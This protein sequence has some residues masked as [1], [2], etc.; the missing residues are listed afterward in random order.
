MTLRI[1]KN[2]EV[3]EK[4]PEKIKIPTK[5]YLTFAGSIGIMLLFFGVLLILSL[6]ANGCL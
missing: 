5:D 4:D 2:D 6:D 1:V 3:P